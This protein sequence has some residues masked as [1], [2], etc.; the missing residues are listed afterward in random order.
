MMN[1]FFEKVNA[2]GRTNLKD[3]PLANLS[4][5]KIIQNGKPT[6]AAMLLFGNH[7]YSIHIGRFKSPDTIIDDLMLKEPLF[8]AVEEAMIFIK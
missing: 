5:L 1:R 7:G 4:K 3:D 2:T 6:L 8:V